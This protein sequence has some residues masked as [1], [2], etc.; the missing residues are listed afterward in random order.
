MTHGGTEIVTE[1]GRTH[2][3]IC[4]KWPVLHLTLSPVQGRCRKSCKN[5]A[6]QRKEVHWKKYFYCY[7]RA[8]ETFSQGQTIPTRGAGYVARVC[9]FL[10]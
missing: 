4:N 1:P 7:K 8:G 2:L 10:G 9:S 3:D 5:T 6:I